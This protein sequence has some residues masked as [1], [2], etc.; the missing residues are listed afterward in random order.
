[1]PTN[2][3]NRQN[4]ATAVQEN[5]VAARV[6]RRRFTAAEKGRILEEYEAASTIE[7]AAICRRER[8]YSS[9]ISNWRKQRASGQ[10]LE[11]K[12]GRKAVPQ[13]AEIT[14]LRKKN[15]ELE[16]RLAKAE[17]VIDVQGKVYAL[18]RAVAGE[19]ADQMDLPPWQKR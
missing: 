16:Q 3:Q 8:I 13:A 17:Q 2:P 5:E 18:L 19:S 10:P 14:Q 1:M 7:R 11:A 6:S 15:I 4:G 12:R 9:H